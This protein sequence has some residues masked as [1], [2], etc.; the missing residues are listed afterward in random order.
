MKKV[1]AI[2]PA[3]LESTRLPRKLLR[4]VC[5]K[6]LIIR[7]CEA[8]QESKYINKLIVAVDSDDIRSVC[9]LYGYE[10][11]MTDPNLKSGTDRIFAAYQNLKEEYD[12]ILN[13]QADEPLI[14]IDDLDNL[15]EK[16]SETEDSAATIYKKIE[17]L[18]QLNSPD[19]VKVIFNPKYQAIYF[20]RNII[21]YRRDIE[22][23]NLLEGFSY[24]KHIGVYLYKKETLKKFV[25]LESSKLEIEEK[26]EQLRLIE[27]GF[28]IFCVE[29]E[30]EIHGV[31]TFEDLQKVQKYFN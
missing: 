23:E 18:K 2:I 15:I 14:N 4:D 20:S 8:I 12:Y 1:I 9:E 22:K 11:I 21:P 16:F 31:D 26:L 25:E 30:N 19:N 6:P 17:D 27:N 24:F 7:T 3:R 10:S 5:G 29:T 28:S 13:V